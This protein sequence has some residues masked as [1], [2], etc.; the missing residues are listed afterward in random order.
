MPESAT[1]E[2]KSIQTL[3]EEFLEEDI[4]NIDETGLFWQQSPTSGLATENQSGI[5]KDKSQI[6]LVACI[7]CTGSDR[8]PLWIIGQVK[9]PYSLHGVN[10]Q[11]L[12]GVWHLNKKA[13]MN[14]LIMR[15]WLISFYFM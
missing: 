6:T 12:S 7:N 8:V 4:Y 15:E 5:K 10:I 11:A 13:W 9:V 2:M 3:C 14:A 1:E